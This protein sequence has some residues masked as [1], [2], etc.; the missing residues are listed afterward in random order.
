MNN[1]FIKNILKK[2]RIQPVFDV[3][4]FAIIIY[5]FH[6]LWWNAGLKHFL[7]Q[8]AAFKE[9]EN[10]LAHQV[11]LPSAWFVKH[12]IGYD[13][14]TINN[15]LYF[16]NNGYIAVEGACSGLKQ[17][18]QWI[19]LMLLFPGPWKHKIWFIPSGL[20]VIHFQNILRII[21]LSIVL[22]HWPA[23]WDFIHLWILRPFYY[24]VMFVLWV[25]WVERFKTKR[26]KKAT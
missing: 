23:Y 10:F 22:M 20:I 21:I 13:I 11:F 7:N 8:Y 3:I 5:G 2:E 9:T 12:V 18:Y 17:M 25:F 16:P 14:N 1:N 6:L 19:T 26:N 15:T 4:I 24:V